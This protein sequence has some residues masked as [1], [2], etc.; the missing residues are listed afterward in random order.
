MAAREVIKEGYRWVICNGRNMHIWNDK[1]IL[2]TETYKVMSPKVPIRGGGEMVSSLLDEES[3][4]WNTKL[5]Q[6]TFLPHEVDVILSIPI[7]SIAPRDSQ[8]WAE[9]PNDIFTVNSTYKVASKLLKEAKEMD[10]NPGFSVHTK[11]R[12]LW[13]LKYPSKI[14][15]F[16]WKSCRNILPTKHCL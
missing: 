15:H 4:A 5:V 12:A 2:V 6:N 7:S 13:D 10:N 16:V 8:V 14:K 11:M 9:T 3:R 1:W